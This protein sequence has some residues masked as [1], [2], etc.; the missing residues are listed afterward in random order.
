VGSVLG[1]AGGAEDTDGDTL[2]SSSD[3][4]MAGDDAADQKSGWQRENNA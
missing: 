1:P 4:E 3:I 2:S